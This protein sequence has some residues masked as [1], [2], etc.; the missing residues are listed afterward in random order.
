MVLR[1]V[2]YICEHVINVFTFDLTRL[3]LDSERARANNFCAC[4]PFIHFQ[5]TS[6]A[7]SRFKATTNQGLAWCAEFDE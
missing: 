1:T 5:G 6:G 2:R 4:V 3:T 7:T